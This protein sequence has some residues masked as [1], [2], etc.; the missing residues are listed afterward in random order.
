MPV[1]VLH[2]R[3]HLRWLVD[4]RGGAY[5]PQELVDPLVG[6]LSRPVVDVQERVPAEDYVGIGLLL[7]VGFDLF[8]V[9]FPV[10]V[11]NDLVVGKTELP[12]PENPCG[13]ARETEDGGG[14]NRGREETKRRFFPHILQK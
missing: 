8:R 5:L 10:I 4:H 2:G 6:V 1:D 9:E 12:V 14:H 13:A 3:F 7:D 11:H